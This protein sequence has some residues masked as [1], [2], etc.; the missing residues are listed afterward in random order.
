MSCSQ[1][2]YSHVYCK[3]VEL[4]VFRAHRTLHVTAYFSRHYYVT[5]HYPRH[6]TCH[7]RH[8]HVSMYYCYTPGHLV[9]RSQKNT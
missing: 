9:I 7:P 8:L 4:H 5:I 2:V 6:N 3:L 1:I